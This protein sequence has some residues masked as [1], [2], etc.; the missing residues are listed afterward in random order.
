VIGAGATLNTVKKYTVKGSGGNGFKV[1]AAAGTLNTLSEN[2][3]YSNG[4]NGY[5]ILGSDTKMSKN[6]AGDTGTGN[7]GDGI[8]VDG[9]N[10][11]ITENTSKSN[12][13]VGIRVTGT[14][15]KLTKNKSGGTAN[16]NN[17]SCQYVVGASNSNGGSNTTSNNATFNFTNA[18]ANSPAGCVPA[19]PTP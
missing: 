14:G 19:P 16:Q 3:A 10:G 7:A 18:G 4:L 8:R 11:D 15:H 5:L 17:G 6:I 13:L 1:E 12:T 2:K 9:N